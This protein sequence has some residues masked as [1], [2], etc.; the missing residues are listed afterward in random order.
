MEREPQRKPQR[1]E[2]VPAVDLAF[3]AEQCAALVADNHGR[4]LETGA[5][6]DWPNSTPCAPS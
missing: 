5:S 3:I 2:G 1:K 6:T 4:Q